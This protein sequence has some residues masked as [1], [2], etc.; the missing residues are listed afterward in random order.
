MDNDRFKELVNE[1][2]DIYFTKKKSNKIFQAILKNENN[3]DQI[4]KSKSIDSLQDKS[5]EIIKAHTYIKKQNDKELKYG[6][7]YDIYTSNI[8]QNELDIIKKERSK[9]DSDIK[10]IM[11]SITN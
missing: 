4:L 5:I 1:N 8:I 3:Y 9:V 6:G 11:R 7:A 10:S 2:I